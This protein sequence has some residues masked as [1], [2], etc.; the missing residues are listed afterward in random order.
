MIHLLFYFNLF[1]RINIFIS[2]LTIKKFYFSLHINWR[3]L[4][5]GQLSRSHF[6]DK[7]SCCLAIVSNKQNVE[8]KPVVS[9]LSRYYRCHL[10]KE[11]VSKAFYCRNKTIQTLVAFIDSSLCLFISSIFPPLFIAQCPHL[12]AGNT[13][14]INSSR[15]EVNFFNSHFCSFLGYFSFNLK[16]KFYNKFDLISRFLHRHSKSYVHV[17]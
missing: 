13:H 6:Q 10:K 5:L 2:F 17:S 4:S 7:A 16:S 12:T 1:D 9:L 11:R 3:E 8:H 14:Y 15:F